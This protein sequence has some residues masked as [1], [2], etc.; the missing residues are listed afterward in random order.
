MPLA[1]QLSFLLANIVELLRYVPDSGGAGRGWAACRT[2]GSLVGTCPLQPLRQ[3]HLSVS[4]YKVAGRRLAAMHQ[5]QL[6]RKLPNQ[7]PIICTYS[8]CQSVHE[9]AQ[10]FERW[11]ELSRRGVSKIESNEVAESL[12]RREQLSWS[13]ADVLR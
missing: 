12:V 10:R 3:R 13:D 2:V 9:S 5:T 6:A 4:P 8:G 1:L 7:R 11:L